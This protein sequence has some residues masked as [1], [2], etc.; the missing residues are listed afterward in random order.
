MEFRFWRRS[1]SND[2]P[3]ASC[4]ELAPLFQTFLDGELNE[5][6]ARRVG[7]HLEACRDCGLEAHTYRSIKDAV[8]RLERPDAATL[9]RLREFAEA[10]DGAH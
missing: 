6:D 4:R 3:G 8:A 9:E 5:A 7:D 2:S 1:A 10:V